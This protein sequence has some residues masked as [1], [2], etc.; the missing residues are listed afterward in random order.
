MI[1]LFVDAY[2]MKSLQLLSEKESIWLIVKIYLKYV[3]ILMNPSI[4]NINEYSYN[5]LKEECNQ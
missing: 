4:E 2:N 5:L 1:G 3:R